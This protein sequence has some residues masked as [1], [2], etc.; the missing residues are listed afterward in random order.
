ML[1]EI[2]KLHIDGPLPARCTDKSGHQPNMQG[3]GGIHFTIL[4]SLCI[5]ECDGE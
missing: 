5:V 4:K 2:L 1:V 3:G